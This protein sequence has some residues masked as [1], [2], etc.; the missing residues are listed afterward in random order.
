ME[1]IHRNLVSVQI[2]HGLTGCYRLIQNG[3]VLVAG[4]LDT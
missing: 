4:M 2:R 1:I 3:V